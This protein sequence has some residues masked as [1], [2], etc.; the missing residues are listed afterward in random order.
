MYF[1]K[2]P[3]GTFRIVKRPDGFHLSLV[4]TLTFVKVRLPPP[5]TSMFTRQAVMNGTSATARSVMF[6]LTFVSGKSNKPH[7]V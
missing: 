5:I 4:K 7:S 6:R 3:I 2:S 1:Y